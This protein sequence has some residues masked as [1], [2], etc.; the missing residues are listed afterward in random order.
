[1]TQPKI[2]VRG[3]GVAGLVTATALADRGAHITLHERADRIGAG[4]SWQAGGMLTPWCE[5][6][7]AP[8]EVTRDSESSILWWSS[9]V[10][11]VTHGGSLVVAP[12]RD[13]PELTRFGRRTSH[14]ETLNGSQIGELEPDLNGRFERALHF[15]T[16]AHVDPRKALHHL[17]QSLVSNGHSIVLGEKSLDETSFDWVI[18]CTGIDA[19]DTD[20]NL[21]NTLRCVRGEML[22]LR[23]L[24]ISLR[25][26]VRMLHP[27]I[28]IYI[29]PRAEKTFMVGATMIESDDNRGMTVR[30]ITD[31]LNAAYTLHPAFAD[32]EIL[33]ANA[34]RRPAFS[35]NIPRVQQNGRHIVLNGMYRHGFLLSPHRAGQICDIVF[36]SAA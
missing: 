18:D 17:A 23:C 4:A 19:R 27:R 13:T 21:K 11:D 15:P 8:E 2:L 9:H 36:G 25:R 10:P 29:V 31:L 3:G 1:M 20:P 16:E 12:A 24:D 6:E 30:S 33:E 5:A 14:F 34:G 26:P 7:A 35:D 32:A 22:I 28:P